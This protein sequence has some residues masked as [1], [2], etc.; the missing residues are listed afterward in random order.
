LFKRF[1]RLTGA[2][3]LLGILV[4][5]SMLVLT[6]FYVYEAFNQELPVARVEFQRLGPD[7]YLATLSRGD[8]CTLE[9]YPLQGDQFQLDAGF[10]KW[11]GPS[12]LMG[13]RPRYRLDRLTGRYQDVQKQNNNAP[14]A[15]DLAPD[16][17][18]DFFDE[19]G[20]DSTDGWLVDTTY[21]SS[22]YYA[23]DPTLRY[24]VYATEDG[25]ILRS[26]SVST[27]SET[28]NLVIEVTDA[29]GNSGD[30]GREVLLALNNLL[31]A[32]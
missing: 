5:G 2:L 22:V 17:L 32:D 9:I 20:R 16:M 1:F 15:H 3:S 19:N 21:G 10:V 7:S 29:C 28:G 26:V 14:I 11:K 25:L 30:S 8:F 4:I 23:I 12:V 24:T 27:Y 6:P 13:F 31:G 18:F